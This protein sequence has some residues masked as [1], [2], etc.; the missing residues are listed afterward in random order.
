M[1]DL[2][3]P[4]SRDERQDE[5]VQKWINNKCKGT[6]EWATGTGFV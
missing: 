3:S 2:F 5:G 6:L 1:R 4:V